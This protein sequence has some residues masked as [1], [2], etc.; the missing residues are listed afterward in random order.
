MPTKVFVQSRTTAAPTDPKRGI[1]YEFNEKFKITAKITAINLL[2][3]FPEV[4]N[5]NAGASELKRIKIKIENIFKIVLDSVAILVP[6]IRC[7]ISLEYINKIRT[8]G[9][10]IIN[11]VFC[12]NFDKLIHLVRSIKYEFDNTGKNAFNNTSGI[13]RVNIIILYAV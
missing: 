10:L 3:C 6:Y 2:N 13:I 7:K 11:K 4:V 9:M 12:R 1:R 5:I 8:N